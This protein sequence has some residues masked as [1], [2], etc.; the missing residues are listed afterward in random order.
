VEMGKEALSSHLQTLFITA[1]HKQ[2]S[3]LPVALTILEK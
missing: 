1:F 3:C 2:R